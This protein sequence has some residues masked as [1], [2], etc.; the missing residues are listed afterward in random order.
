MTKVQI[1]ERCPHCLGESILASQTLTTTS[2]A[3]HLEQLAIP[4]DIKSC[5]CWNDSLSEK[6]LLKWRRFLWAGRRGPEVRPSP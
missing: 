6:R 3:S 5:E 2:E 4:W 1:L